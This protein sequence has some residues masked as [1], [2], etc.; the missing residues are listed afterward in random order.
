MG[1]RVLGTFCM[2]TAKNFVASYVDSDSERVSFAWNG[3]HA[4][5]FIDANQ[6]IRWDVV[7]YCIENPNDSPLSL[8]EA[9]LRADAAW[10]REAWCSPN[11]F[12]DLAQIFLIRGRTAALDA[13]AD[14]LSASFDTFGACH[15]LQLPSDILS[16]LT[17]ALRQ[18][19]TASPSEDSGRRLKTALELFEKLGQGTASQGWA[20][21]AP[22][23]PITNMRV[24]QPRWYHR[25]WQRLFRAGTEH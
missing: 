3:K 12:H 11:H 25:L 5:K 16:E 7:R 15:R 10:A 24:V 4:D 9:L 20:T 2:T 14:S 21:I 8:L 6:E 22:G 1:Q 19:I 17:S 13:F 18:R 23:T